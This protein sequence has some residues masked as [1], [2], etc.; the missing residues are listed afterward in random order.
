MREIKFRAWDEE[1]QKYIADVV[2]N[3]HGD[4]FH[5]DF[6]KK[7]YSECDVIIEQYTGLKDK[8]G[9][10]I[11]EGDTLSKDGFANWVVS[12]KGGSFCINNYDMPNRLFSLFGNEI[13][14]EDR[15]ISCN[16]HENKE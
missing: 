11:Y 6:D 10:E 7:D 15:Y 5:Y 13:T 3:M 14:T 2:M 4:T 12:F 1:K 16:I 9:V 8:N